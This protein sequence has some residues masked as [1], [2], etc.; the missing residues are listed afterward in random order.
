ML[1]TETSQPVRKGVP[2]WIQVIVWAAL[3]VLMVIVALGLKRS[4]QGTVAPGDKIPDFTLTFFDGYT[5]QNQPQV[6]LSDLRGKV[7]ILNFFDG[8]T[9]QNQPQV[10]LSDLRGKVVIL[11]FW[12]SWCKPCEEE[13]ALLEAAWKSYEADGKVIFIG[14]DYVDTE[15]EAR[16]YLAKFGITYPNGPDL[17]TKISQFFR[18]KGV[19]ETYFIDANGVLQYVQI[20]PFSSEAQIRQIIDTILAQ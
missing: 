5:Y 4:Q 10:N 18:I 16:G 20:G 13:A 19:P 2:I 14:A 1:M 3:A 9:Y 17:G 11:N 6:N 12:A 15:P 8:Y 7:V